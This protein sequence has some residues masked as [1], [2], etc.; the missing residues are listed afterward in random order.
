MRRHW[1]PKLPLLTMSMKI[2]HPTKPL[3]LGTLQ[4]SILLRNAWHGAAFLFYIEDSRMTPYVHKMASKGTSS[5]Y[6]REV[7][8][9][10]AAAFISYLQL[11]CWIACTLC[12]LPVEQLSQDWQLLAG[13]WSCDF[14]AIS[15][16]KE[17]KY[18]FLRLPSGSLVR[19][20]RATKRW[21]A[22][23]DLANADID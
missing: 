12:T 8:C 20:D 15:H 14:R 6:C 13:P 23:G 5:Y 16:W 19:T 10:L 21:G 2:Y 11:A 18:Q 7:A 9:H 3:M 22:E 17:A 1:P 4:A